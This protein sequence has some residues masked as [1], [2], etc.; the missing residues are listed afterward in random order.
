MR[1]I[2]RRRRESSV[3][4]PV[5]NAI[6]MMTVPSAIV[7]A[8]KAILRRLDCDGDGVVVLIVDDY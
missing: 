5:C 8:T 4:T 2:R 3:N 7:A 1:G 6:I